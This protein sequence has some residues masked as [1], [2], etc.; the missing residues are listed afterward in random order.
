MAFP[1]EKATN[2]E[3]TRRNNRFDPMLKQFR[4]GGI[5]PAM[6]KKVEYGGK[7]EVRSEYGHGGK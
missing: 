3:I 7:F 4:L 5:S 2:Y 6:S 1:R